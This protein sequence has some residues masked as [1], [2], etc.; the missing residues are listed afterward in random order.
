MESLD[1]LA[2]YF[3]HTL[4]PTS[5]GPYALNFNDSSLENDST[6]I[7]LLLIACGLGSPEASCYLE[8]VR[9]H[10]QGALLSLLRQ[11]PGPPALTNVSNSCI[12][13]DMGWAM[14]R[15]SWED[16]ATLLAMKSGHTWNH[17][18]AD[19]G[20]FIL[21]KQGVPLII[22]SGTCAYARKEYSNYYCQSR[23][24][25][26]ILFDCSGQPKEDIHIGCKFPGHMHDL[27]DGLGLKYVYADATGAHGPLVLSQLSPLAGR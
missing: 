4:Y 25:N 15:S 6:S 3:L 2:S 12:Y 19:A 21:F 1:Q 13:P 18:H 5:S 11:Y 27:V 8:L 26:V 20:S 7:I 16:N 17:A 9:T 24:H 10:Q 22:D 23:A 14:M